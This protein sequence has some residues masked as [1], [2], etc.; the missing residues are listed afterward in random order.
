MG[1]RD[2]DSFMRPLFNIHFMFM[3]RMSDES[4]K[5]IAVQKLEMRCE[6]S[7]IPYISWSDPHHIFTC[8]S[9]WRGIGRASWRVEV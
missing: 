9:H 2:N 3:R 5:T 1:G 4:S 8:S 7:R 6:R